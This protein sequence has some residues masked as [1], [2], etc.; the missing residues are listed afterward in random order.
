M[1][2]NYDTF[3]AIVLLYFKYDYTVKE[4]CFISKVSI[5]TIS[6]ILSRYKNDPSFLDK[7]I[8]KDCESKLKENNLVNLISSIYETK[9]QNFSIN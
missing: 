7:L 9:Q 1:K 3:E 2:I 5:S 4:L 6:G 8:L